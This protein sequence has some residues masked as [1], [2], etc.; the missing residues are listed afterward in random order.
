DEHGRSLLTGRVAHVLRTMPEHEDGGG[1]VA[2]RRDAHDLPR[3]RKR[4][5]ELDRELPRR[6]PT[7]ERRLHDTR[8]RREELRRGR[9][10]V[11]VQGGAP[12]ADDRGGRRRGRGG[13][14]AQKTTTTLAPWISS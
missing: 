3:A 10:V 7:G 8:V 6:E 4:R 11:R 14:H 9:V 2:A 1:T 12:G 13:D 5:V